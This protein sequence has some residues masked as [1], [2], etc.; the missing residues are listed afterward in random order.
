MRQYSEAIGSFNTALEALDRLEEEDTGIP[1]ERMKEKL[2][3]AAEAL[4]ALQEEATVTS[5]AGSGHRT[6][7][8]ESPHSVSPDRTSQQSLPPPQPEE[9]NR[10]QHTTQSTHSTD[11]TT[12]PVLPPTPPLPPQLPQVTKTRKGKEPERHR[13]KKGKGTDCNKKERRE[14]TTPHRAYP[15]AITPQD[16]YDEKLRDYEKTMESSSSASEEETDAFPRPD[17]ATHSYLGLTVTASESPNQQGPSSVQLPVSSQMQSQTHPQ[18]I[19]L[20]VQENS[21]AI[22]P[23][24][25]GN[26]TTRDTVITHK[27]RRVVRRTEIIPTDRGSAS[28]SGIQQASTTASHTHRDRSTDTKSASK[29]CSVS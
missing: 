2:S 6:R 29:F 19:Q 25:R 17:E 3:D 7:A 8:S 27:G 16:S 21:L 9:T 24:A 1:R 13:A 4:A 18:H 11:T 22:G 12:S 15:A 23:N 10:Q 28:A 26:Y 5:S 20:Q 14:R